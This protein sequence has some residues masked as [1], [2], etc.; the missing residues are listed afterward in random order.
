MKN[1]IS[2]IIP[3]YNCPFIERSVDSVI[4]QS[5]KDWEIIIIDNYSKNKV[6]EIVRKKN[7]PRIRYFKCRN[8]GVIGKSRNYGIRKARFNW[9]AFLDSDDYWTKD[10]LLKITKKIKKNKY[11]FFYHNMFVKKHEHSFFKK[12]LYK[13]YFENM[14]MYDDLIV[15]GNSIIQSSVVVKKDLIKN[16]GYISEKKNFI[17]WEDYDLWLKIS[18]I[19]NKFC[20][21]KDCL[22]Y[23][24]VSKE[25]KKLIRFIKNISQFKK[26]YKKQI[27][28]IKT[29]YKLKNLWW[30]KYSEVLYQYKKKDYKKAN[31]AIQNLE[32]NRFNINLRVKI[33]RFL[34]FIKTLFYAR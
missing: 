2:I 13:Y 14:R 4:E 15:N 32:I 28:E 3:T 16:V 5:F 17:A 26:N 19:S 27:N 31:L 20:F 34:I 23:Y 18:M 10:K 7:D 24:Y 12:K 21:N 6:K 29:K 22:G 1:K 8:N 9:V 11:D 30:I 25:D 33:L